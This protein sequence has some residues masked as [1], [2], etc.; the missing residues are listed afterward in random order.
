MPPF[1]SHSTLQENGNSSCTVYILIMLSTDELKYNGIIAKIV[2]I[3]NRLS[4]RSTVWSIALKVINIMSN[5][6]GLITYNF[7]N[8]FRCLG[9]W[10]K[11]WPK[12]LLPAVTSYIDVEFF[13]PFQW[14]FPFILL[15]NHTYHNK[16]KGVS[17]QTLE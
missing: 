15:N 17:I 9:E 14:I 12:V 16:V 3:Y 11:S 4:M 5:F 13:A 1:V 10:F 8:T 6:C 7:G 2:V